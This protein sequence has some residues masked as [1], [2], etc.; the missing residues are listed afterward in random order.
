[1][2]ARELHGAGEI[3]PHTGDD[4]FL[5]RNSVEDGLAEVCRREFGVPERIANVEQRA[6]A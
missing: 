6:Q 2:T 1:M 5:E 4:G 3:E